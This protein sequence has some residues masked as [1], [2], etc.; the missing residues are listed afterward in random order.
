MN[1]GNKE[2]IIKGSGNIFED[3]GFDNSEEMLF[4]AELVSLINGVISKRKLTQAKAAKQIGATQND[5]SK[6]FNGKLDGFSV[7]RLFKFL[8]SLDR[9][10][11]ISVNKTTRKAGGRIAIAA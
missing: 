7:E 6:L 11:N 8:T 4:K 10:I 3:L 5:V 1:K 2:E 9:D